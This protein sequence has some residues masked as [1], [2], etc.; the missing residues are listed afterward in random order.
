MT[1]GV[2][3]DTSLII[4]AFD[5]SGT[6]DPATKEA[7]KLKVNALL[8]DPG[9]VIAI[10]PLIRYE[11][12]RGVPFVDKARAKLL[13]DVLTQFETYEIRSVEANLAADLWRYSVSK[14][15]KPNRRSF[16]VAHVA[17]A[18]AN[19]LE[20]TSTDID[21]TKLLSLHEEMTKEAK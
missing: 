15:H 12:L 13:A 3:L 8:S 4:Q 21:I 17:S 5:Q 2:L 10:T 11:V 16:D 1:R 19:D 18:K 7:A 14:G 20:M 6:S 9:V